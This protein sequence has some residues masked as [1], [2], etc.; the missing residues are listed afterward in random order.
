MMVRCCKKGIAYSLD[1]LNRL[2]STTYN[3]DM[4]LHEANSTPKMIHVFY[5]HLK[6]I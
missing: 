6:V 1:S 2:N 4:K 3:H 5:E